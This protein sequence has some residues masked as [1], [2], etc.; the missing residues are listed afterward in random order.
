VTILRPDSYFFFL[1]FALAFAP[2]FGP[3]LAF[4]FFGLSS[5]LEAADETALLLAE[6][7][8]EPLALP[9][10]ELFLLELDALPEPLDEAEPLAL[11]LPLPEPELL[12]LPE[13]AADELA[14]PLADDEALPLAAE[15]LAA[16]DEAVE[17]VAAFFLA[18]FFAAIL[19]SPFDEL[20][21]L[22]ALPLLELAESLLPE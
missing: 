6:P 4:P 17:L 5:E 12:A 13:L 3:G 14:E 8:A 11:P 2:F 10:P 1:F 7:L 18:F 21:E 9:D 15:L 20:F 22:L 16:V 19:E